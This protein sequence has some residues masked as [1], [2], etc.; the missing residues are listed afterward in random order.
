MPKLETIREL[1]RA[2]HAAGL[3]VMLH[4]NGLEAQRFGVEAGVDVMVHGI[5]KVKACRQRKG[6]R[7]SAGYWTALLTKQIGWQATI[8]VLY[9]ERDLFQPEIP[10]ATHNWRRWCPP[11]LI[12]WYKT[13]EGQWFR[14]RTLAANGPGCR[15][16]ATQ[17]SREQAL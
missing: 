5:W 14:R 6:A 17:A 8:Q 12:A 15:S 2:A 7:R 16:K 4:A 10:F 13:P 1:V 11:D 3:P 9:G